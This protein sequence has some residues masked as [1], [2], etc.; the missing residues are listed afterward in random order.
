MKGD[1]FRDFADAEKIIAIVKPTPQPQWTDIVDERVFEIQEQ[2]VE[3]TLLQQTIEEISDEINC[4][5][6]SRC[7]W[8]PSCGRDAGRFSE[9][10]IQERVVEQIVGLQARTQRSFGRK[11]N[12]D[13]YKILA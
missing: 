2:F 13:R 7:S 1:S 4:G 5:A 3:V 10:R 6:E 9:E 8:S 12:C 11:V